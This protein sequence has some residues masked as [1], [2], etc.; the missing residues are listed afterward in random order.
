MTWIRLACLV[1][2]VSGAGAG[3]KPKEYVCAQDMEC[4]ASNG[5][6]GRCANMHCAFSDA[7]CPSG[8][9]FD[10]TAG[11]DADL[12]VDPALLMRPD[13]APVDAPA[14]IDAPPPVG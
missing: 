6:Y 1:L 11:S 7:T 12:C 9:R 10:D 4:V 3:C 5:G 13:A 14:A 8:W 2:V